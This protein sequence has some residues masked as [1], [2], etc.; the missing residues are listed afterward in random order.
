MVTT[1]GY[2]NQRLNARGPKLDLS[3]V[4]LVIFDEADEIF[5]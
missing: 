5:N 3:S 4:K 1:L 2:I